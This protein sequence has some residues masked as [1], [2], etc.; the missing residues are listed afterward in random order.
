MKANLRYRCASYLN[1][2]KTTDAANDNAPF[3]MALAA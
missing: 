3:E 2:R 1:A